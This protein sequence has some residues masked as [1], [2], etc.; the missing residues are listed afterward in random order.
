MQIVFLLIL[1]KFFSNIS[2]PKDNNTASPIDRLKGIS[3][4][5]I[6]HASNTGLA[7]V[8]ESGVII[9][10]N[11]E[12]LILLPGI[13]VGQSFSDFITIPEQQSDYNTRIA[14]NQQYFS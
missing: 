14:S 8:N 9:D 3:P 11:A 10:C 2:N 12:F 6:I 7:I 5:Q 13:S 4:E 1:T